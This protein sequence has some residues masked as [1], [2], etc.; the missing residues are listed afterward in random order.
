MNSVDAAARSVV[1]CLLAAVVASCVPR[2]T[3]SPP[4]VPEPQLEFAVYETS[5]LELQRAMAEG[6]VTSVQLVQSY[7]HR[8]AAYDQAGPA[9]NTMIRLNPLALQQAAA[10]DTERQASGPRGPL[11]GI[12]I[13][14]K[15]NYDTEEMPTT[16]GSISL[17]G[18]QPRRDAVVTAKL[19]AAGA[20][21]LGKTNMMEFAMGITTTSSLGGQTL[22][23]YDLRRYPGGSSGGSAAAVAASFAAVAWGTDTCGSIRVPA[24]FNALFGLRPT[25]GITST[26]GIVP[27]CRSQ[28]VSAPLARTM[29]DLAIALDATIGLDPSDPAAAQWQGR[30]LPR[31]VESLDSTALRGARLGVVKAFFGSAT[32]SQEVSDTV[33]AAIARMHAAGAVV[34]QLSEPDLQ[35]L[36]LSASTIQFEFRNQLNAYLSTGGGAPVTSL[37]DILSRGLFLSELSS[38]MAWLNASPDT[39]SPAYRV[40]MANRAALQQRLQ[41]LLTQNGLDAL[42]Y[43]TVRDQ[44]MLVG[45]PQT[46]PNCEASANSGFPALSVPV[47]FTAMGLPVGMEL[48]GLPLS[49]ARLVAIGYAWERLA[50][51]RRPPLNTPQLHLK[52]A[53]PP[54]DVTVLINGG[55]L[56]ATINLNFDAATG[57][58]T[59][60]TS[61]KGLPSDELLAISLHH[62][63]MGGNGPVVASFSLP[64]QLETHGSTVLLADA[65]E[66]LHAGLLYITV[67]TRGKPL[68]DLRAAVP[69]PHTPPINRSS[70]SLL[71]GVP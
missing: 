44:P 56:R 48:L 14:L 39:S 35:A 41:D 34:V 42:V 26:V 54:A 46:D 71:R 55:P 6:R 40:A 13:L 7:L 70:N 4:R 31:F 12:P 1:Y 57:R 66:A 43:P 28:D 5:I 25:K 38:D 24:A 18:A 21:I 19:R 3:I 58:L 59:Y 22:N 37:S 60:N 15:D 27:L 47:G 11:H 33:Q 64:G 10:L 30:T 32:L 69:A 67:L 50:S 9:L 16:A 29:T 68:G 65:R 2:S 63:R 51:P 17:A 49:D 52:S 62:G 61:I 20:V 8:I 36:A 23:P 45:N 53:P